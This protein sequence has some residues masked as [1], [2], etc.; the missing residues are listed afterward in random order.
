MTETIEDKIKKLKE[1]GECCLQCTNITECRA[2][3]QDGKERFPK[4]YKWSENCCEKC[5]DVTCSQNPFYVISLLTN[6]KN[7]EKEV[8][9]YYLDEAVNTLL[10]S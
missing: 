10:K 1:G 8:P 9:S 4:S 7:L 3:N 5:A 2:Y 6:D